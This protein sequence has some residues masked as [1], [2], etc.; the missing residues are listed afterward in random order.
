MTNIGNVNFEF[1]ME[2]ECFAQVL[3]GNWDSFCRTSFEYVADRVLSRFDTT[4]ETIQLELL[5]LDLGTISEEEFYD[6]FPKKLEEQL[7]ETFAAILSHPQ[8]YS[9][10]LRIIPAAKSKLEHLSFYLQQGYFSWDASNENIDF[11]RL[12]SEL[13][14]TNGDALRRLIRSL[15]E[16]EPMRERLVYQ[17]SDE[18]LEAVVALLEPAESDFI[19]TYSRLLISLYPHTG[20]PEISRQ[21]FR[22]AVQNLIFA[23][24]LYPNRGYFNRKQFVWQTIY[25]LARRYN[26]HTLHLID[27]FSNEIKLLAKEMSLVP[28]LFLILSEI[29]KEAKLDEVPVKSGKETNKNRLPPAKPVV[30]IVE[31]NRS[32][33]KNES[34]HQT[35]STEE[36]VNKTIP[37]GFTINNAGLVLFSPYLPRLFFMLNFMTDDGKQFLNKEMQQR[38]IFVLQSLLSDDAE[39]PE[40]TLLLNKLL[41][42]YPFSDPLPRIIELTEREKEVVSTL[43]KAVLQNW[44]KMKNTSVEGFRASFLVRCG[45]LKEFESRWT[46]TVE[47]R[48]YDLLLDTLPWNFR[49]LRY[50]YT[51]KLVDVVWR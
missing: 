14:N 31:E 2:N 38:A 41:V 3:Y 47:E 13:L 21:N 18:V 9:E 26:I 20:H 48:P 50:P 15:G 30:R 19:N 37:S 29:R 44:D 22:D 8:S 16:N 6:R 35:K 27:L 34:V 28:E 23:Y 45:V 36:N 7:K 39:H 25:G 46:V 4:G 49:K 12:L 24:L 1:E 42:G 51:K 10:Q 33:K 11:Q 17:L 40:S 5:T 43:L 32:E